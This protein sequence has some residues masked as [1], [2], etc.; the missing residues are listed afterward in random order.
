MALGKK[1]LFLAYM[2][3]QMSRLEQEVQ[4]QTSRVRY[5]RVDTVDCLELIIAIERLNTFKEFASNALT[6]LKFE[7]EVVEDFKE[8]VTK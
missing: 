6:L 5:R 7:D 1:Q 8:C 3:N 2:Y 4:E